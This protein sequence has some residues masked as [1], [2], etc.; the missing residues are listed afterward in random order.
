MGGAA[1]GPAAGAAAVAAVP[2]AD[3]GGEEPAGEQAVRPPRPHEQGGKQAEQSERVNKLA[4]TGQAAGG[5][6]ECAQGGQGGSAGR[7]N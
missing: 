7:A 6:E 5:E 3:S 4:G 2:L 1:E